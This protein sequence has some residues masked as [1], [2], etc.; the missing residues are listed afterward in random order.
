M[1]PGPTGREDTVAEG[2]VGPKGR[3]PDEVG[4]AWNR[5]R[6]Q[7]ARLSTVK[8][9]RDPQ[10]RTVPAPE[11]VQEPSPVE[12]L[13]A[14]LLLEHRLDSAAARLPDAVRRVLGQLIAKARQARLGDENTGELRHMSARWVIEYGGEPLKMRGSEPPRHWRGNAR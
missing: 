8:F 3:A 10:P 2:G 11:E 9:P 5:Y 1:T 6:S 4:A 12:G 7:E 13:V 14:D